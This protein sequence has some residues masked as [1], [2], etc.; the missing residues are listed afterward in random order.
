[1]TSQIRA[2]RLYFLRHGQTEWNARR[3]FQGQSDIP[4][5]DRGREQARENAVLM[6]DWFG[7]RGLVPSFSCVTASPL[8][9]AHETA[10][11]V[12]DELSRVPGASVPPMDAI[13]LDPGLMEQDYGEWEG[14]ALDEIRQRFPGS[15][16]RQFASMRS[17]TADGGEPLSH[18]RERV[19][20]SICR[21]PEESLVVGHF[22][23]L[24]AIMVTLWPVDPGT[25]PEI[26]QDAFFILDGDTIIRVDAMHPDGFEVTPENQS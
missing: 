7:R 6:R 13:R 3:L 4:L 14:L 19:L 22:G 24:Y 9:R 1:M 18:L 25:Y 12:V 10:R 8:Q 21:L 20:K 17:F 2:R 11:I 5:N 26:P 23:T 15:V 16:E